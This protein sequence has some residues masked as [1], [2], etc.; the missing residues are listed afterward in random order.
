[1]DTEDQIEQYILTQQGLS[2]D[3]SI[4]LRGQLMYL[5]TQA[6][7]GD[8]NAVQQ[9]QQL[10]ITVTQAAAPTRAAGEEVPWWENIPGLGGIFAGQQIVPRGVA[11][12]QPPTPT[13]TPTPTPEPLAPTGLP[14]ETYW[15]TDP[16]SGTRYLIDPG[17]MVAEKNPITGFVQETYRAPRILDTLAPEELEPE[18][19]QGIPDFSQMQTITLPGGRV[20]NFVPVY[21][22]TGE[23]ITTPRYTPIGGVSLPSKTTRERQL[24]GY[25]QI[26]GVYQVGEEGG[27]GLSAYQSAQ[28]EMDRERLKLQRLTAAIQAARTGEPLTYLSLIRG[29]VVPGY[30]GLP[31][32][33]PEAG[34]EPLLGGG[35]VSGGGAPPLPPALAT[36]QSGAPLGQPTLPQGTL[37]P[38]GV[39]AQSRLTP[40]ERASMLE[41]VEFQGVPSMDYE[42]YL[43]RLRRGV[44]AGL[45]PTTTYR[46]GV[47]P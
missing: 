39:Q 45:S 10:G 38:P 3:E 1:M 27:G 24:L 32:V 2:M 46:V 43:E 20:A 4:R 44:G 28:L 33:V 47:S 22:E 37:R 14:G 23:E 31:R 6:L 18:E 5:Y 25:E 8:T 34:G 30:Q 13:P 26:G 17:G 41:A 9:L 7:A 29:G 36:I 19:P 42:G 11:E 12:T 21:A 16:E 15:Y 40:Y 35:D